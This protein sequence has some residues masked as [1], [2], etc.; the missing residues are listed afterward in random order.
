[1]EPAVL[2]SIQAHHRIAGQEVFGPVLSVLR[3]RTDEETISLANGVNYGLPDA[4][5]PTTCGEPTE[6]AAHWRPVS[7]GSTAQDRISPAFP[8]AAGRIPVY[9]QGGVTVVAGR[10]SCRRGGARCR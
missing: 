3:F 8:T 9:A 4:S 1:M 5:T 6:W 7:S 2:S 10:R